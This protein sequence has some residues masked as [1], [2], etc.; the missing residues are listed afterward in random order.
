[1]T[2]HDDDEL[3][4]TKWALKCFQNELGNG[5]QISSQLLVKAT[6]KL[7]MRINKKSNSIFSHVKNLTTTASNFSYE[8][9]PQLKK[10]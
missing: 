3:K 10:S 9:Y 1:M 6:E 4:F 8:N 5:K 7:L 2:R